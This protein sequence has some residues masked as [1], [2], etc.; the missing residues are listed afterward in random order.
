MYS[1][2]ALFVYNRREHT[3]K[4]IEALQANTIASQTEL[5]IF[6]D[7]PK[8]SASAGQVEQVREYIH[9]VGGFKRVE[10]RERQSNAGLANSI[11]AGVTEIVD[12]YGKVIVLEDDLVTSP[13]FLRFMNDSLDTYRDGQRVGSIHG[14]RYPSKISL[15]E[16]FFVSH[17]SSWGW[18]TWKRSWDLFEPDGQKLLSHLKADN[19]ISR[20]NMDDAYNFRGMLD[21]Q[22]AGTTDS[23][24]IR[25]NASLLVN[26]K[27]SLYPGRPLIQNIGQDGTGTHNGNSDRYAV[28]LSDTPIRINNIDTTES[29]EGRESFREFFVSLRPTF[30]GRISAKL[31]QILNGV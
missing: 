14:Y 8:D 29:K 16:T 18:A 12:R 30:I 22:I 27:L 9:T 23:W 13:Y 11:I 26:D 4:T 15:P 28:P 31:R 1:P 17:A 5:F 21:R 3:K 25:W 10:I 2:V 20:F 24:A 7:G 19:L 6:S